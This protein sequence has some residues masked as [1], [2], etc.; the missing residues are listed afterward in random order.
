MPPLARR[1]AT[2]KPAPQTA[3]PKTTTQPTAG[4]LKPRKIDP[5]A[6]QAA[7]AQSAAGAGAKNNYMKFD[8]GATKLR[9]VHLLDGDLPFVKVREHGYT[10]GGKLRR[11]LDFDTV[12]RD[13]ETRARLLESGKLKSTDYE[14]YLAYG[15]PFNQFMRAYKD[16]GL[17]QL[18]K[19]RWPMTKYLWHAVDRRTGE[20]VVYESGQ[21]F[22]EFVQTAMYGGEGIEAEFPTLLD[23]EEGFDI[24]V[25][26]TGQ[27]LTRRYEYEVGRKEVASRV[28]IADT[29]KVPD[30]VA[31]HDSRMVG[32]DEKV[33]ALFANEGKNCALL[34]ITPDTFGCGHLNI[35]TL[36]V[37]QDTDSD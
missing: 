25:K 21:K 16:A 29:A 20:L 8:V 31:I 30:L 27:K 9:I 34:G 5:A 6:M 11:A 35:S 33:K 24:T 26:A 37:G 7:F 12:L 19:G 18:P 36:E 13:D 22:F 3:P 15:D 4:L 17:P 1:N 32:Y 28:E 10:M 23:P 2:T 14:K